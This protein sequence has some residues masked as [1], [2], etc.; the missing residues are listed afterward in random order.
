M[1]TPSEKRY[2]DVPPTWS[3]GGL[4]PQME[5]NDALRKAAS[6][7]DTDIMAAA[8]QAGADPNTKGHHGWTALHNGAFQ[9]ESVRLLLDHGADPNLQDEAGKTPLHLAAEGFSSDSVKALLEGGANP[10]I[11]DKMGDTPLMGVSTR[12]N[13]DLL[14]DYGVDMNARNAKGETA[15]LVN[16]REK[17]L[18]TGATERLAQRGA[19]LEAR[20]AKGNTALHLVAARNKREHVEVLLN[21][22]ADPTARNA[23]DQTPLDL[24]KRGPVIPAVERLQLRESLEQEVS[25]QELA[26]RQRMRL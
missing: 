18:A 24:I 10:N 21:N 5:A 26:P 22:G 17:R 20:D 12:E 16:A 9:V 2:I 25:T 15:L 1:N 6:F 3:P 11:A 19:D 23:L 7:G 4:H 14:A 13:V 8:L